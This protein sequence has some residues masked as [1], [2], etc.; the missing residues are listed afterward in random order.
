MQ[1]DAS[2]KGLEMNVSINDQLP[3]VVKGDP[4]RLKEALLHLTSY[5]Y[6][7]SKHIDVEIDVIR[8]K[9]DLTTIAFTIQDNGP[10][11]SDSEL[12]VR[13]PRHIMHVSPTCSTML[14]SLSSG[15]LSGVRTSPGR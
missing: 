10:G 11:M 2:R 7:Q 3:G 1:K 14:T 6:K 4:D 5:A 8:T 12:D 15:H 13:A 9:K